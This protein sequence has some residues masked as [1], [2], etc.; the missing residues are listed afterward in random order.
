[1]TPDDVSTPMLMTSE[2]DGGNI[3]SK[4]DQKEAL[5]EMEAVDPRMKDAVVDS[6]SAFKF[7]LSLCRK[8]VC[9]S[10]VV[11]NRQVFMYG[12]CRKS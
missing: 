7:L 12:H 9:V 6:A 8:G 1:M 3:E 11:E 10:A 2:A 5:G 4:A